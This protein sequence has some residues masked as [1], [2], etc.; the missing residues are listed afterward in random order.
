M[1]SYHSFITEQEEAPGKETTEVKYNL[2]IRIGG[3]RFFGGEVVI[4]SFNSV[5]VD[6]QIILGS[7]GYKFEGQ[8]Y[9]DFESFLGAVE[10]RYETS[11]KVIDI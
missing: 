2:Q 5:E 6:S 9:D 7:E 8:V 10:T 3:D 1:K 4:V 11:A